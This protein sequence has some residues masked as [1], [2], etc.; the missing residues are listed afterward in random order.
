MA[1]HEWGVQDTANYFIQ[2][3]KIVHHRPS[4]IAGFLALLLQVMTDP[5]VVLPLLP[6]IPHNALTDWIKA[7]LLVFIVVRQF[8]ERGTRK[9]DRK[10]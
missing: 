1:K 8:R 10:K 5:D 4:A 3:A 7:S 2:K 6:H 9:G